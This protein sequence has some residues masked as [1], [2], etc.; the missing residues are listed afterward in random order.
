LDIKVIM[1]SS[2]EEVLSFKCCHLH[3]QN[4]EIHLK[5]VGQE[6]V[7]VPSCFELVGQG[8]RLRIDY[9]YPPGRYTLPPGEVTACYC[10]LTDEVYARFQWIVFRDTE[11]RE[12]RAPLHQQG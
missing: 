3:D 5:N 12:H 11:G 6:P 10:S 1:N 2:V 8:E 4:L 7:T 9:L